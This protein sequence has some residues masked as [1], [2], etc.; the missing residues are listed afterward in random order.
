MKNDFKSNSSTAF[1][2]STTQSNLSSKCGE[3]SKNSNEKNEG[4]NQWNSVPV[5]YDKDESMRKHEKDEGNNQ[6]TSTSK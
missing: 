1:Q 2:N 6:W 3:C 4:N 5:T